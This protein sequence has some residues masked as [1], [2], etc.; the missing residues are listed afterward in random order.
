MYVKVVHNLWSYKNVREK[1]TS[2]KMSTSHH[3]FIEAQRNPKL[4]QLESPCIT[5][6]Q[7]LPCDGFTFICVFIWLTSD[8][9]PSSLSSVAMF[10]FAHQWLA[11]GRYWINS[12]WMY[13]CRD[14]WMNGLMNGWGEKNTRKTQEIGKR[15]S[16][17][18]SSIPVVCRLP[19]MGQTDV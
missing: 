16:T 1:H 11:Q 18:L 4:P 5:L 17:F 12:H 15:F 10:A 13:I 6:S 7:L 2:L 3:P 8:S 9:P 14:I 19:S